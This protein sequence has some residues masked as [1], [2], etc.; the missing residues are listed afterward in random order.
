MIESYTF[1]LTDQPAPEDNRAV[2]DGLMAFNTQFAGADNYTPLCIFMRDEQGIIVGGLI[3]ETF[4]NWV[5]V[6]SLWI[7][8]DARHQG[9]GK[10]LLQ[11]AEDE[12][13]RRGCT[14]ALLDTLSFQAL[15]FYRKSGYTVFGQ[16]DNFPRPGQTRYYLNKSL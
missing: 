8:E 5:Y 11:M 14:N 10:H 4:W 15:D 16:L 6:S 9:S 12:A 1:T 2:L 3:G 13:R 7:H